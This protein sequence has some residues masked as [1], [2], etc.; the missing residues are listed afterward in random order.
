MSYQPDPGLV[1]EALLEPTL[2]RGRQGL[3]GY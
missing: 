2:L 3:P 1:P